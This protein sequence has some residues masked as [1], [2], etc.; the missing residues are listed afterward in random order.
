MHTAL[1]T[2]VVGHAACSARI[3]QP[4]ALHVTSILLLIATIKYDELH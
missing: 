1:R 3:I 2:Q 4:V